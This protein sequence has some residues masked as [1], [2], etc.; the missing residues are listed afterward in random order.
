MINPN[1][2]HFQILNYDKADVQGGQGSFLQNL[3]NRIQSHSG[4][5]LVKRVSKE[6]GTRM[7]FFLISLPCTINKGGENIFFLFFEEE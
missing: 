1:P 6:H 7:A 4:Y 2:S 5:L 3:L